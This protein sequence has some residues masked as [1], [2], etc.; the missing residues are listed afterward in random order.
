MA[1]LRTSSRRPAIDPRTYPPA[2]SARVPPPG[3]SRR[4]IGGSRSACVPGMRRSSV[5]M[6]DRRRRT[7][8]RSRRSG[9][10]PGPG[11]CGAKRSGPMA[12]GRA[13]SD[14]ESRG[15][16][17]NRFQTPSIPPPHPAGGRGL[18]LRPG[19]MSDRAGRAGLKTDGST[20]TRAFPAGGPAAAGARPDRRRVGRPRHPGPTSAEPRGPRR[21]SSTGVLPGA[22]SRTAFDPPAQPVL[23]FR[24]L[25]A[26]MR[27]RDRNY[28]RGQDLWLPMPSRRP[29]AKRLSW[30]A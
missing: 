9:G 19:L 13:G 21:E 22:T 14:L 3:M 16:D 29:P 8:D 28:C 30:S 6:P 18:G 7:A 4:R 27:G 1:A 11:G 17:S 25:S 5:L 20:R 2:G 24:P 26:R 10:R 15:G 23:P 12:G